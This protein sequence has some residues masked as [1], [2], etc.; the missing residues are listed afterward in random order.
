MLQDDSR[1]A[2]D[3]PAAP[4]PER[5]FD[6]T[7]SDYRSIRDLLQKRT[8]INLADSK[9]DLAY[10]RMS[11]LVRKRGL[12][13]VGDYLDLVRRDEDDVESEFINA[14]TTNVTSFF[15]EPLQF[16]FLI[17]E[18]IPE[19]LGKNKSSKKLRFWSAACSTGQEPYSLA[20]VLNESVPK[21][22]GWD[23]RILATDLDSN[24]LETAK[25]GIYPD[26]SLEEVRKDRQRAWFRRGK[27]KRAGKVQV[28][29]VLKESVSFR[30][31]N[32]MDSWPL[33][34]P[35]DAIFCRNVVIY[36]SKDTQQT[37]FHRIADLLGDGRCLFLGHSESLIGMTDRFEFCGK[38]IYRK[39]GS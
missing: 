36:F 4:Q 35:L 28:A 31:L 39:L 7:E 33:R 19:L 34:G 24:V 12:T 2:Q 3:S 9:R 22:E 16:E 11:R 6:F 14:L 30:Q 27:G 5:E 10:G 23:V 26:G 21:G 13:K 1:I 17:K 37:L 15:R 29:P 8:G 18:Y 20:M 38:N 32:L 25:T